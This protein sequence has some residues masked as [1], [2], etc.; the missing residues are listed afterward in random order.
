MNRNVLKIIALISMFIDHIGLVFFP[1]YVLFR[2]VGRISM[3]LFAFF[4]AEGYC[5][6]RSKKRYA[7]IMF[8]F[9]LISWVPFNLAF[10]YPM[11][12]G[13]ILFVF[14]LSILGMHLINGYRSSRYGKVMYISFM[15]IY[16]LMVCLLD[17]FAIIPEGVFGVLLPIVFYLF[18]DKKMWSLI[19]GG[20][21]LVL[22]S[23]VMM[24]GLRFVDFVQFFSL[25][26]LV[27]IFLYNGNK[28][29]INL[30]YLFYI[31][32]PCHFILIYVL[33][34]FV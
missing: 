23:L 26:S 16:L 6:T 24:R 7:L 31:S 13:N 9:M 11:Y 14:L 20:I 19:F 1:Q 18:K 29:K 17:A 2:V 4:V 30:K 10:R 15:G 28:G 25:L 5:H 33:T 22:L 8:C 34:L 21:V 27:L 32:Y 12:I 3:P